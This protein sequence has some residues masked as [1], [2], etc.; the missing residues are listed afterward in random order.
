MLG[1]CGGDVLAHQ[2]R[3]VERGWVGLFSRPLIDWLEN[4][5]QLAQLCS[6]FVSES[7]EWHRCRDEKLAPHIYLVRLWAAPS[8]RGRLVGSLVLIATPGQGLRALFVPASGG[9]AK[10]FRPDLFDGDWGYGPYFHQ[11]FVER[12]AHWFQ[13]PE[14]PFPKGTWLNTA[15][16]GNE[17]AL[18]LLE[19][20]DIV[21]SE[22]GDLRI[23]GL[24][25][26]ILRA[27]L[28][29]D[30]DMWCDSGDPPP[31]KPWQE[32]RIPVRDLYTATGHLRLHVKY[33]RGC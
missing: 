18:H 10:E 28:E 15:D 5:N 24:E 30:S 4:E 13:L 33:T 16:L 3:A 11:T 1:A 14:G 2:T 31:L 19:P 9:L 26:D 23:L 8:E 20:D 7:L 12:R 6:A 25:S 17:P 21:T 22:Y 27:R 29:Q 32:I